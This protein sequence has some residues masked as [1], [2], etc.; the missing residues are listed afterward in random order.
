MELTVCVVF[1]QRPPEA[2]EDL[3][4]AEAFLLLSRYCFYDLRPTPISLE[5][6]HS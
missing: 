3:G 6:D 1:T 4:T 5:Q 2:L